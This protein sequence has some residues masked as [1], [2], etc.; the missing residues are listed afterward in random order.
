MHQP[1]RADVRAGVL[2]EH[3]GQLVGKYQRVTFDEV[4]SDVKVRNGG[5]AGRDRCVNGGKLQREEA[6]AHPVVGRPYQRGKSPR[7]GTTPMRR[8]GEVGWSPEVIRPV[9]LAPL[10]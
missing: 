9:S 6:E 7:A 4:G 2:G 3:G 1:F 5:G 8:E 10:A